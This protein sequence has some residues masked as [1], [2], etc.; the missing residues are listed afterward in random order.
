MNIV[1]IPDFGRNQLAS[2]LTLL[3]FKVGVEV[4]VASGEY[5]EILCKYN[6]NMKF[7]GVDPYVSYKGYRDYR[8]QNTLNRLESEAHQRLDK[9]TNYEFIKEFSIGAKELFKDNTIDFVYLDGNH[10]E[11]YITD[12]IKHWFPKIKQGGI[13]AGH[14]Y[15][16]TKGR[17]G[18]T[19]HHQVK[20]AIQRFTIE[21]NIIL[22]ILG[23]EANN[24]GIIRDRP[25]SWLIVK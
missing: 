3:N 10:E 22:Y 17:P 13:L 9:Y 1:E 11:P 25:R 19:A 20:Q 2:L 24:E 12:D 21:N 6:P 8:R 18:S 16:N 15:A 7:Y 14:D 23:R 5:S 4:G